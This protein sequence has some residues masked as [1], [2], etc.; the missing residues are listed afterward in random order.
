M[1]SLASALEAVSNSP[2][3]PSLRNQSVA[4]IEDILAQIADDTNTVQR[5]RREIDQQIEATV[6]AINNDINTIADINTQLSRGIPTAELRDERDAAVRSLAEK[7]DISTFVADNETISVYTA[8]GEGLVE[9]NPNMLVYRPAATVEHDASFQAIEVYEARDIDPESGIPV[10]GAIGRELVS[11][12]VRR[13]LTPELV[14][15]TVA[16]A[17]Q[18]ITTDVSRGKLAGLL[19][20]RDRYLP[21][22]SDQL[23]ELGTMLRFNLNAAHNDAV[24]HPLPQTLT[25]T[26]EDFTDFDAAVGAGNTSGE[27]YVAVLDSTGAVVADIVVDVGAAGSAA[28]LIGQLNTDL[29]GFGTATVNADGALEIAL[30]NDGTGNPYGLA[31]SEGTSSVQFSDDAGHNFDYGFSHY[32]GLNDIVVETGSTPGDLAVRS[33]I[34]ADNTLLSRVVL[35]RST[36]AAVVGGAG[37]T[38]GLQRLAESMENGFDTVDRGGLIG[39]TGVSPKDF[40]SDLIGFHAGVA[41]SAES[42]N[43]SDQSLVDELNTRVGAVSG[44]NLDEELSNLVIYQ[45]AYNVAARVITITS[46]LF[47]ELLNINR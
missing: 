4:A 5:M 36:G 38:R 7:I 18:T 35:D 15:D 34:A 10:T 26:N 28:G 12:G 29:A 42:R 17:D 39:R 23:G 14:A 2:E 1:A 8:G 9:F 33:D 24:P 22:I 44:V 25:G 40:A 47:D 31:L 11:G 30:G 19:E 16:D 45:Q 21:E 32:F 41:N 6:N 20:M 46:E 27:A 43:A 13:S 3:N 37:D